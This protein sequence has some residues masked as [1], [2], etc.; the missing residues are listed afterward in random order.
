MSWNTHND[1]LM[2]GGSEWERLTMAPQSLSFVL[3]QSIPYGRTRGEMGH[4]GGNHGITS[5]MASALW[6]GRSRAQAL[7]PWNGTAQDHEPIA[8]AV[9]M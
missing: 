5:W 1:C 7:D 6:T 2:R 9:G 3:S 8:S 4:G